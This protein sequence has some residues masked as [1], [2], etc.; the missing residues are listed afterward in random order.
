MKIYKI[1]LF[2]FLGIEIA[3]ATNTVNIKNNKI[4]NIAEKFKKEKIDS[5]QVLKLLNNFEDIL[6]KTSCGEN[7]NITTDL[8]KFYKK[9]LKFL[10]KYSNNLSEDDKKEIIKQ[11][12]DIKELILKNVKLLKQNKSK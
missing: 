11:L 9:I 7:K 3:T 10:R 5:K 2:L 12:K 8:M 1:L 4:K 6:V